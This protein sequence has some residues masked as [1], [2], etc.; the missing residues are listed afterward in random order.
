MTSVQKNIPIQVLYKDVSE[1]LASGQQPLELI[2]VV[3]EASADRYL[4][5]GYK[6]LKVTTHEGGEFFLP[7]TGTIRGGNLAASMHVHA[8]Y[9]AARAADGALDPGAIEIFNLA[10]GAIGY[11]LS[12]TLPLTDHFGCGY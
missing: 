6:S 5:P 1:T 7:Y 10:N 2:V 9:I 8:G 4:G 11:A 3:P 12:Q